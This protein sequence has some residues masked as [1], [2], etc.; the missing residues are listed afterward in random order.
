MS[1]P[2]PEPVAISD[3]CEAVRTCAWVLQPACAA[4]ALAFLPAAAVIASRARQAAQ[5]ALQLLTVACLA[6]AAG[7]VAQHTSG[8]WAAMLLDHAGMQSANVAMV[9]IGLRRWRGTS[10]TALGVGGALVWAALLVWTADMAGVRR[11]LVIGGMVPCGLIEL[12]LFFRDG[13]RTAYRWWAVGW[14]AF[15]GAILAWHLDH[16]S[17]WCR[18]ASAWQLHALWHVLAAVGMA[19]WGLYYA[20]FDRLRPVRVTG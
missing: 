1:C 19:A 15:T 17:A 6:M 18:P 9:L 13:H 3:F 10:W 16:Q 11:A 5:P 14:L 7:T 12:R 20:Q 8:T 2:W 4:S